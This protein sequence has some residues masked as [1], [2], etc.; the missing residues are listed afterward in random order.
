MTKAWGDARGTPYFFWLRANAWGSR[1]VSKYYEKM[2]QDGLIEYEL[3]KGI[4]ASSNYCQVKRTNKG[5]AYAWQ[6][7]EDEAKAL[8]ARNQVLMLACVAK[9][10]SVTGVSQMDNQADVEYEINVG[11]T[12]FG[13]F[14]REG[15][16]MDVFHA[17]KWGDCVLG[18]QKL[19]LKFKRYDDGWRLMPELPMVV[20]R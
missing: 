7:P 11:L 19:L 3:I 2:K 5:K 6:L 9:P 14:L 18:R 16:E 4:T 12:S 20:T 15:I 17:T 13:R 1:D 8:A 10:G